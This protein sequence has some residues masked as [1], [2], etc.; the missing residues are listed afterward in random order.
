MRNRTIQYAI[1]QATGQVCS[2]VGD[3]MAFPILAYTSMTPENNFNLEYSL[4][5]HSIFASIGMSLKWTRKIPQEIKNQHREFW[6]FK[7]L[8]GGHG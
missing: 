2:Q 6:G 5:K 1:D 8:K 7:P 4:E 3:E